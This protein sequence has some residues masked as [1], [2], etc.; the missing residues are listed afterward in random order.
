MSKIKSAKLLSL[1][2]L[3]QISIAGSCNVGWWMSNHFGN[4]N[5]GLALGTVAG[6]VV[7]GVAFFFTGHP[8]VSLASFIAVAV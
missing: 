5:I 3:A 7:A 6:A 8:I 2:M 1:L 4:Q